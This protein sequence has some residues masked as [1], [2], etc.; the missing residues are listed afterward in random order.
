MPPN[1][2]PSRFIDYIFWIS[3]GLGAFYWILDA[4]INC[5]IFYEGTFLNQVFSPDSH[6]I[7][8]RTFVFTLFIVLGYFVQIIAD[9]WKHSAQSMRQSEERLRLLYE[10]SPLIYLNI[11][12]NGKIVEINK[13]W[14]DFIMYPKEES[15]GK[16]FS[17]F[18]TPGQ[19][20]HFKRKYSEFLRA[21]ETYNEHY[22]MV[23]KDG[24]EVWASF[25]GRTIRD[26]LGNI[27]SVACILH[28]ITRSKWVERALNESEEKFKIICSSA[29]DAIIIIDNGGKITFWNEA[30]ERTLG[31]TAKEVLGEDLHHLL[32]PE[33]YHKAYGKGMEKF[34][35]TG[36]GQAV[37]KILEL[38]A[39][40][41][42][43]KVIP[44]E[45]SLA[46]AMINGKWHG[47]GVLRDITIRK[48]YLDTKLG[49]SA[50][51]KTYTK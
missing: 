24:G 29:L 18:L 51:Q 30:A 15:V 32:A 48:K 28:D 22:E 25:A 12:K 8:I 5:L 42:T 34:K 45:L 13:G 41:S 35:T 33:K 1:N 21:G 43:G 16:Y 7:W 37:G 44:I 3:L 23:R 38:E 20:S 26:E 9:R 40:T 46:A 19:R 36:Q 27:K 10:N 2:D 6:N 14:Q 47:I 11:D 39:I 17:D 49:E 50:A 31:Y 4:L